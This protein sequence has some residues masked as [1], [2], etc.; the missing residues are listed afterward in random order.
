MAA[1]FLEAWRRRDEIR[2]SGDSLRPWLL[3]VATNLMRNHRRS[4]RRRDAAL[5]RVRT[6][7]AIEGFADDVAA[8]VDD[9]H[10]MRRLLDLIS[11]MSVQ[12]QEVI[13][14]VLWSG[15]TYEEAAVALG[16]AVG[17]VKSRLSRARRR[18]VELAV[19][20]GHDIDEDSALARA[21][22]IELR[23]AEG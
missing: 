15:L 16:V 20:S 22:A 19:A 7:V 23:K 21:S 13:S 5:R 11:S 1:T 4:A 10:R 2:L 14:L 17:T 3:G 8:R 18:L 6:E 9:E 12:E